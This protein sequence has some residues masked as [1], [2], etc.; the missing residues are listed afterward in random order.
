MEIIF[1]CLGDLLQ[2]RV[3]NYTETDA[4]EG[5]FAVENHEGLKIDSRKCGEE[6]DVRFRGILCSRGYLQYTG[7]PKARR[8]WRED[9]VR[10]N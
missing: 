8:R 1:G 2:E 3:L 9:L 10:Y 5:R 7:Q 6:A 4:I